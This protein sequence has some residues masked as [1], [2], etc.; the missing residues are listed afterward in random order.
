[1][2]PALFLAR[3]SSS[4]GAGGEPNAPALAAVRTRPRLEPRT[5]GTSWLD[6]PKGTP[7]E[8]L[9]VVALDHNPVR[10]WLRL[11]LLELRNGPFMPRR[12]GRCRL[13][14]PVHPMRRTW[15]WALVSAAVFIASCVIAALLIGPDENAARSDGRELLIAAFFILAVIAFLAAFILGILTLDGWLKRRRQKNPA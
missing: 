15:V 4:P 5:P 14:S 12:I 3:R 8:L 2:A 1:M 11:D 6:G 7:A 10:R 9:E 13:E